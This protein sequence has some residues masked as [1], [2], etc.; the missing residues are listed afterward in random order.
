MNRLSLA[1][2]SHQLALNS[3]QAKAMINYVAKSIEDLAQ[4]LKN[5]FSSS[6]TRW[7]LETYIKNYADAM[8]IDKNVLV[9]LAEQCR[10]DGVPMAE[11]AEKFVT[12]ILSKR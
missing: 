5:S 1:Y 11:G 9:A 4:S 10:L 2:T 8:N 6:A 3:N 7:S 12:Q